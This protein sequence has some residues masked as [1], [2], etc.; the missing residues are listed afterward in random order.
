MGKVLE[1]KG[2]DGK[3]GLR[4]G[5]VDVTTRTE[6]E[7]VYALKALTPRYGG[8]L[9]D[10]Y[11]VMLEQFLNER[12]WVENSIW[13]EPRGLTATSI[14]HVVKHSAGGREFKVP[15][16]FK[17]ATGFVQLNMR[18][19]KELAQRVEN[20]AREADKSVAT[21]LYTAI[22]WWLWFNKPPKA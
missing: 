11:D 10:M 9:T 12:L 15:R 20:L 6:V 19:R 18:V 2:K 5:Y 16:R 21:V 13:R 8:T 1:F 7:A 4:D 3:A 17:V 14:E 22:A